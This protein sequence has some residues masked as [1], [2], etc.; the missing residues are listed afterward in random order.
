MSDIASIGEVLG[1]VLKSILKPAR[2]NERAR[3]AWIEAAGEDLAALTQAT[4]VKNGIL[5]VVTPSAPLLFELISYRKSE[6][7]H[8]VSEADPGLN[9]RDIKFRLDARR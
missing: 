6:L 9:V 3:R 2:K 5:Y 4:G 1:G 8:R 7:L